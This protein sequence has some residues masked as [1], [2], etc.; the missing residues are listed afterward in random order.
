[1]PTIRVGTLGGIGTSG[2]E[3]RVILLCWLPKLDGVGAYGSLPGIGPLAETLG[4]GLLKPWPL[5]PMGVPELGVSDGPFV[6]AEKLEL[7]GSGPAGGMAGC[8][9]N[10]AGCCMLLS[11]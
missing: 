9:P 7:A 1:L 10:F 6:G 2:T 8:G 3:I 4:L 5:I 11:D